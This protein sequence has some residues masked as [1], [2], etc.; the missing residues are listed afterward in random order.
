MQSYAMG[1]LLTYLVADLRPGLQGLSGAF[2]I[3]LFD[4]MS[5]TGSVLDV[6]RP[7]APD[8]GRGVSVARFPSDGAVVA[9]GDCMSPSS[10]T[11]M[12][13]T[14]K[15]LVV[16]SADTTDIVRFPLLFFASAAW[17]AAWET[18]IFPAVYRMRRGATTL[19]DA[20][21]DEIEASLLLPTVES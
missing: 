12:V 3:L 9:F 10:S 6:E 1:K 21:H 7:C 16:V 19:D 17:V 8:V 14:S 4:P 18:G 20:L 2:F 5:V 11:S 15:L 13:S